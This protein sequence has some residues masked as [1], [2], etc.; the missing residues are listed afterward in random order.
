MGTITGTAL[1]D[2]CATILMD[3]NN[4][5]WSRAEMILY[6]ND[7]QRSI[8]SLLPETSAVVDTDILVAGTRQTIPATSWMLLDVIRNMGTDGS[9]PGRSVQRVDMVVFDESTP[10]WQA[11]ASDAE[12]TVYMYNARDRSAFYV[13]PQSPATNYLEIIT[14]ASH[15]DAVEATAITID[16]VYVS[17]LTDYMLWRANSKSGSLGNAEQAAQYYQL[18]ASALVANG[19]TMAK[20]VGEQGNV[21]SMPAQGQGAGG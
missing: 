7:G 16:D 6:V 19:A 11:A 8:I 13:Y 14:S 12:V 9:T 21:Q 2:R 17:I 5:K 15:S 3:T 1:I 18:Y 4:V 10:D 20:L